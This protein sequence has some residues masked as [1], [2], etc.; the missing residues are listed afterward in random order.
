MDCPSCRS[1][2]PT[3]NSLTHH[4]NTDGAQCISALE[5]G[6]RIPTP[7]AFVRG[8]GETNVQ[9]EFCEYS[10]YRFGKM[11]TLLDR[12][13]ENEHER[14]REHQ[15]HYPFADEGEWELA[16]FLATNLNKTQVSE[17]LKLRWVRP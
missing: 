1:Q 11:G 14:R 8:A 13:K 16:K 17:F 4:F 12:L 10:G 2:F 6:F 9:G 3:L 5:D 7:P 15:I